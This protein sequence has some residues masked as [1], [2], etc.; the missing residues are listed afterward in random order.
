MKKFLFA[1]ATLLAATNLAHAEDFFDDCDMTSSIIGNSS[2]T[3][4]FKAEEV[5]KVKSREDLR[6]S[7]DSDSSEDEIESRSPSTSKKA[8]FADLDV[9]KNQKVASKPSNLTRFVSWVG[10]GLSAVVKFFSF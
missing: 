10:R 2:A 8:V 6:L 1:S 7:R 3:T 9:K 4:K 5:K